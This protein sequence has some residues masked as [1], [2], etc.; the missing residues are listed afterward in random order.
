[1]KVHYYYMSYHLSFITSQSQH[2]PQMN[3]SS[4]PT[5][6]QSSAQH[7]CIQIPHLEHCNQSWPAL[8]SSASVLYST[9]QWPHIVWSL[10]SVV[11]CFF[12]VRLLPACVFCFSTFLVAGFFATLPCES[13]FF[14]NA[15]RSLRLRLYGELVKSVACVERTGHF[16]FSLEARHTGRGLMSVIDNLRFAHFRCGVCV[17]L[18][19]FLS[20]C[21]DVVGWSDVT[22]ST[23]CP[24]VGLCVAGGGLKF[25]SDAGISSCVDVVGWGDGIGSTTDACCSTRPAAQL[26]THKKQNIVNFNQET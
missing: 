21:A 18:S 7:S 12:F 24:S 14:C 5:T 11:C 26:I 3:S 10:M 9:W 17:T 4:S 2:V 6:P 16:R 13:F 25:E 22:A 23:M 20:S 1:M 8:S 19:L 15:S